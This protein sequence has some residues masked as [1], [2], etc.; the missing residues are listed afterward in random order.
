LRMQNRFLAGLQSLV[1]LAEPSILLGRFKE[2]DI[3]QYLLTF[4]ARTDFGMEPVQFE[5]RRLVLN[6]F[7]NRSCVALNQA[8]PDSLIL[9]LLRRFLLGGRQRGFELLVIGAGS[10]L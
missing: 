6:L 2:F 7:Q 9:F 10:E 5:A 1:F 3:L 8:L 4:F